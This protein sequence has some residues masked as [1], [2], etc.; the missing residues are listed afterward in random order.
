MRLFQ[1]S[2]HS[3]KRAWIALRQCRGRPRI[4]ALQR[5]ADLDR[6]VRFEER[7]A[8]C[9]K[10]QGK[11]VPYGVYD[12]SANEGWITADS[13]GSN[14]ARVGLWKVELQKLANSGL[15]TK[16][17][18]RPDHHRRPSSAR[19]RQLEPVACNQATRGL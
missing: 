12:I 13:G 15:V 10:G 8:I 3:P 17:L 9:I 2:G 6:R 14:G 19:H 1:R 5:E 18:H 4:T 16:P 11:A 7:A